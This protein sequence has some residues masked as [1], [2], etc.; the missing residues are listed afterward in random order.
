[1]DSILGIIGSNFNP[2]DKSI[3]KLNISGISYFH[4][5]SI[6]ETG[7]GFKPSVLSSMHSPL[8][9]EAITRL[10]PIT[11]V[12]L[13]V[14]VI[15][16]FNLL[17]NLQSAF[18]WFLKNQSVIVIINDS[19]NITDQ[20]QVEELRVLMNTYMEKGLWF[21]NSYADPET[22]IPSIFPSVFTCG[23][24]HVLQKM[25][26]NNTRP[27][28]VDFILNVNPDDVPM[29]AVPYACIHYLKN[30]P[31]KNIADKLKSSSRLRILPNNREEVFAVTGRDN[32]AEIDRKAP[33][34]EFEFLT[35]WVEW[36]SQAV[37]QQ[38][39]LSDSIFDLDKTGLPY[40]AALVN[41]NGQDGMLYNWIRL[42]FHKTGNTGY[43]IIYLVR[44]AGR[45][46]SSRSRIFRINSIND[47]G[48]R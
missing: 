18:E 30:I 22:Q 19:W 32:L 40:Q 39:F 37:I 41:V 43:Y 33:G 14:C 45:R 38:L 48:G 42:P 35:V 2:D 11:G 8:M 29:E 4:K 47:G 9:N 27:E 13:C 44:G 20:A 15:E 24:R 31:V 21:I 6:S 46:I 17:E 26:N 28:G 7:P 10:L 12:E 25:T 36:I 34:Q 3:K 23:Y 16:Q 5:G 1:M